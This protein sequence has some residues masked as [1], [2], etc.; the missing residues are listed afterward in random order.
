MIKKRIIGG[1]VLM[2]SI[3]LQGMTPYTEERFVIVPGGRQVWCKTMWYKETAHNTPLVC[4]NGGPGFGHTMLENL[5]ALAVDRPVVMYDQLG[6]GKSMGGE[7]DPSLWTIEHFVEELECVLQAHDRKKCYLLGVSWGATVAAAYTVAYPY[8]V[9][10]L[11]LTSPLLST[12]LWE[13]DTRTLLAQLPL[14]TQAALIRHEAAG[15]TDHEEYK[16]ALDLYMKTFVCRCKEWPDFGP[17][18]VRMYTT[19]W[20]TSECSPTGTLRGFNSIPALNVL[21]SIPILITIGKYDQV[22]KETAAEVKKA[23][24]VVFENSSH[25]SWLEESEAYMQAV[26]SFLFERAHDSCF[27]TF[28]TRN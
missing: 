19:M 9:E 21:A 11:I 14:D 1:L 22:S 17:L 4:I 5:F 12:E 6:C 15:T 27:C 28:L 13:R 16:Q 2:L 3:A 18:N 24:V 20:G 8:S 26:R 23:T 10:A 7:D 25:C